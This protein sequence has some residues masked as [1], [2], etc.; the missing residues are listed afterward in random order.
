MMVQATE[1]M[2]AD[3][4]TPTDSHSTS[5]ITQPSSSKP[6]KKK[7]RRKQRTCS[8]KLEDASKQGS[9]MEDLDADAECVEE[10]RKIKF[11][12][13]VE[14]LVVSITTTTKSIPVS[15]AEVVTPASA[16]VEVQDELTL[17]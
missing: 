14:E 13:V 4:A 9:K 5:I 1:D 10:A 16:N 17:A 8:Y 6:Q 11:E 2:G 3:S 15:A 12:K 7:S